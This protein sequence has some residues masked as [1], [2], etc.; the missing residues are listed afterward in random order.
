MPTYAEGFRK[1]VGNV[2]RSIGRRASIVS[3]MFR[4]T[5][6]NTNSASVNPMVNR[7][8][9]LNRP[10]NG[11][12]RSNSSSSQNPTRYVSAS[13]QPN[14]PNQ[15]NAFGKN[16]D[17]KASLAIIKVERY[18]IKEL[19][20]TNSYLERLTKKNLNPKKNIDKIVKALLPTDKE[21]SP[22]YLNNTT[23]KYFLNF[24]FEHKTHI[25]GEEDEIPISLQ[26]DEFIEHIKR[27][28]PLNY[29][30]N[31][32]DIEM[33]NDS[34]INHIEYFCNYWKTKLNKPKP[35]TKNLSP[36]QNFENWLLGK[37]NE[38]LSVIA[39]KEFEEFKDEHKVETI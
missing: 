22:S 19:N 32:S 7:T 1:R 10:V 18:F 38:L 14:A 21:D 29:I 34:G 12:R 17:E 20:K 39:E 25:P 27:L 37:C 30:S 31:D 9:S 11:S 6:R 26:W 28:I 8:I 3:N 2:S 35:K 24:I 36:R 13:K 23:S 15:P 16:M 33:F 4:R 5:R